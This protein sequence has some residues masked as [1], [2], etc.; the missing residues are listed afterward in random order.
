[1][2]HKKDIED[3]CFTDFRRKVRSAEVLSPT[4]ERLIQTIDFSG[5]ITLACKNGRVLKAA[6]E[7][8]YFSPRRN[9]LT[10]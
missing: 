4:F 6:Y 8:S 2:D 1:M 3:L 7:E 5:H 9:R 10:D